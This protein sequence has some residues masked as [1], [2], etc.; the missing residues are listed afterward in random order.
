MRRAARSSGAALR[1]AV[2]YRKPY[3]LTPG[4][5]NA[6]LQI[7]M[8]RRHPSL[9]GHQAAAVPWLSR[10]VVRDHRTAAPDHP[11]FRAARSS[12]A[13]LLIFV[14]GMV[15]SV[16]PLLTVCDLHPLRGPS[17]R[18]VYPATVRLVLLMAPPRRS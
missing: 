12:G 5:K 2:P 4:A 14:R 16:R 8:H 6:F 18:F 1:I 3:P 7:P 13:A 9:P 11:T 10:S 17:G 15:V